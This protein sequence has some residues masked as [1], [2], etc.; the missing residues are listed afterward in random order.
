MP[1]VNKLGL[2]V[3]SLVFGGFQPRDVLADV[4]QFQDKRRRGN[5]DIWWLY[6][7]GGLPV[8]L[9]HILSSRF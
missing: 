8:M 6:D 7:D 9:A 2:A 5:I 4:R 3:N 1:Q